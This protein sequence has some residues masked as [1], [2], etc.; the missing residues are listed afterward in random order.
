[1]KRKTPK[2]RRRST[3]VPHRML[4]PVENLVVDLN[5]LVSEAILIDIYPFQKMPFAYP[6]DD[7][8][9][10][11]KI[12]SRLFDFERVHFAD[13]LGLLTK[14]MFLEGNSS[15]TKAV[16]F[17]WESEAD[18]VIQIF[19]RVSINHEILGRDVENPIWRWREKRIKDTA[20]IEVDLTQQ[21]LG[22]KINQGLIVATA[23]HV[24][25]CFKQDEEGRMREISLADRQLFAQAVAEEL[26]LGR[27]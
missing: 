9:E 3:L 10:R 13:R 15:S 11:E 24:S 17:P 27:N 5:R 20:L 16:A 22:Q 21:G 2:N 8:Q 12:K 6:S 19:K 14:G 7:E 4:S 1:M 18:R 26:G 23:F 25:A